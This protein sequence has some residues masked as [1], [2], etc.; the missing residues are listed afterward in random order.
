MLTA[1][2]N[3][4]VCVAVYRERKL[5]T[6]TNLFLISLAI[7]DFMVAL[8]VMP[9]GLLVELLNYYPFDPLLCTFWIV[10]DVL[11]CTS[12]IHHMSTM[13]L[14]RYLTIK[15]P[16][17]YGRNK[18]KRITFLKIIFVW[19]IS[20]FICSPILVLG[21]YDKSNVFDADKRAC[22]LYNKP[23]RLYGSILAF[24][25]PFLIML[26]AYISTIKILKKFSTKN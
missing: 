17:K 11:C 6:N 8:F 26:I 25:I 16:F 12:S 14:D 5:Q 9:T 2:G 24:Y 4:L 18:S 21:I 3:I 7:A 22:Q 10:F 1:F 23:F 13:A 19:V 15:F 20:F